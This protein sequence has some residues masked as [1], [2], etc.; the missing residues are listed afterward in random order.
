M[1]IDAYQPNA[2]IQL[3]APDNVSASGQ[4][5]GQDVRVYHGRALGICNIKGGTGTS[6]TLD[7][8]LQESATVNG[9][10]TDISGAT[11]TQ[12]TS[13]DV[14][15]TCEVDLDAAKRFIRARYI[16]GGST[17]AFDF[18]VTLVAPKQYN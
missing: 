13:A 15:N 2:V 7:V 8:K 3:T 16:L 12:A 17:P 4:G 6:Q 5:T 10:Y 11:F 9:T 18:G 1:G 14:V